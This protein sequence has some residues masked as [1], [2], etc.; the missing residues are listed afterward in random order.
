MRS[1][2]IYVGLL[3]K[4]VSFCEQYGYTYKFE[5]NKFYGTPY[6]ENGDISYEGIKDYRIR[7]G[8][9]RVRLRLTQKRNRKKKKT[10]KNI[11]SIFDGDLIK[12]LSLWVNTKLE[13]AL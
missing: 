11:Y 3:D 8:V 4:I 5:D 13:N 7:K 6:E 1:K 9:R 10:E 2:Q 12:D